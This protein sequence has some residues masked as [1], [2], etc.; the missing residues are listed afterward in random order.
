[1]SEMLKCSLHDV[2]ELPKDVRK[3]LDTS[4]YSL[5]LSLIPKMA[6]Y[7]SFS[8]IRTIHPFLSLCLFSAYEDLQMK[9]EPLTLIKP[10]F[11]VPMPPLKPA[12]YPPIFRDCEP[13][14]L[15][16]FDLEDYFASETSRLNQLTNRCNEQDLD[17]F[18]KEFGMIAGISS[19][20]PAD[21]RG[22]KQ[23]LDFVVTQLFEF[24]RM[25]QPGVSSRRK[26]KSM[27]YLFI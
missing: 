17:S 27:I 13:P 24:K 20:M 9:H 8:F 21:Q 18:I 23:I 3:L 14:T 19:R 10:Q 12:V 1:M 26:A 5:D 11:E 2:E 4:L 15:E 7:V 6:R 22:A 16:L 25:Y